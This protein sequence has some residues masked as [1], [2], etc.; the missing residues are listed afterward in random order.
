MALDDIYRI[1]LT[2]V[3]GLTGQQSQNVFHYKQVFALSPSG[4]APELLVDFR[5]SVEIAIR[6]CQT[7]VVSTTQLAV[8]NIIPGTDNAYESFAPGARPGAQGGDALP[9]H[10][11]WAF[12]INR[13][14]SAVRN[15]QKRF[16]GVPEAQQVDGTATAIGFTDRLALGNLLFA[17]LGGIGTFNTYRPVIYRYAREEEVIPA[18]TIPALAAADFA[19]STA[20]FVAI[21]SQNSRKFGHGS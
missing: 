18:K 14:S 9:P 12:R 5:D 17:D 8:E 10:V 7:G 13:V 20:G 19:V 11:A 15:G 4:D 16:W 3:W 1:R 2:Q 6:N 21:T